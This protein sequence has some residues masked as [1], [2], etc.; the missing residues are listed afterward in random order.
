M[1]PLLREAML[2]QFEAPHGYLKLKKWREERHYQR[3]M[4]RAMAEM[5]SEA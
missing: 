2:L 5:E 4:K 3:E 1:T